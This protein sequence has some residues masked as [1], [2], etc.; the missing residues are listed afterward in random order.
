MLTTLKQNFLS[1]VV[2]TAMVLTADA[3]A[4]PRHGET[5]SDT[6][7]TDLVTVTQTVG[8]EYDITGTCAVTVDVCAKCDAADVVIKT[9]IPNEASYVK[10]DPEGELVGRQVVWRL[11]DMAAGDHKKM[12]VWVE[13]GHQCEIKFCTTVAHGFPTAACV[14]RGCLAKLELEKCG[15]EKVLLGECIDY[16]ITL[17][18][19]GTANAY[20]VEL[21]DL[22]PDGLSHC[23]GEKELKL[24]IDCLDAGE[25]RTFNLRLN[26]D[27]RGYFCNE[28]RAKARNAHEVNAQACTKVHIRDIAITKTGTAVQYI[29]RE[30]D[31]IITVT[32]TG[33]DPLHEVC[34]NDRVPRG[35]SVVDCGE[36]EMTRRG[37]NWYIDRL[38][39]GESKSFHLRLISDCIGEYCN[40]VSVQTCEGPCAEASTK[41]EYRGH[42]AIMVEAVDTCD[43]LLVGGETTYRI[44]VVNQ[45]TGSDKNVLIKARLSDH[46][47]PTSISGHL[48]GSI[49][50]QEIIFDSIKELCPG[51]G[52]ELEIR[53]E[54]VSK[55]DGRLNIQVTSDMVNDPIDEEESTH[56]Y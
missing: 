30:S 28:V 39:A 9:T 4:G 22:V 36:G 51:E 53:A 29:C 8:A 15:P 20:D 14:T 34:I 31:Y 25:C 26:A 50:G 42:A 52:V 37:V 41:T 56:V 16:V 3:S 43:P 27:R 48:E 24:N 55:G 17:R 44:R 21:T 46:L 32:N 2:G 19:I 10:S 38:E 23:T 12:T 47:K 40:E 7:S 45:G 54:A 49:E 33:D 11:G 1:L 6:I 18:N 35:M 13:S 5:E